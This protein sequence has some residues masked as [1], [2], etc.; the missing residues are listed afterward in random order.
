M[1]TEDRRS[2]FAERGL[3]VLVA[4]M[5]VLWSGAA[6]AQTGADESP[7]EARGSADRGATDEYEGD[8]YFGSAH[9]RQ[10][11]EEAKLD[12]SKAALWSALFPGLGNFYAEQYFIGGLNASLMGFTALLL[13][14]GLVTNQ[15]GFVWTSLG[16]AGTAY[17][18]GFTTSF[19]GV[20]NYNRRLRR[21]LRVSEP[22]PLPER[23][24][25]RRRAGTG[26]SIGFRF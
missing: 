19:I 16:I 14:Y 7:A 1:Q 26:I 21:G 17:V 9:R 4:G 6:A 18:S 22:A 12:Y 15:M 20:K 5:A 11:Y 10:L 24:P 25:P 2:H 8:D 13:P 23:P 3:A